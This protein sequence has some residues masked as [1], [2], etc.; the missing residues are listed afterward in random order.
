MA[1]GSLLTEQDKKEFRDRYG[2]LIRQQC[3]SLMGDAQA[4]RELEERVIRSIE[5]KY[6]YQP[7]PE[8]C[9]MMLIARCCI[10]SSR[11]VTPDAEGEAKAGVLLEAERAEPPK[12]EVHPEPGVARAPDDMADRIPEEIRNIRVT[13][14]YDPEKTALWL[15]DGM[16]ADLVREQA[17][18]E[19]PEEDSEERSVPHSILNTFLVITFLGSVVF[20]L[21]KTGV[22]R[23]VN[24][25]LEGMLM[26]G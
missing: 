8:H 11:M 4:A 25:F 23:W 7:L 2:E 10:L 1:S 6:E 12:P 26:Y 3:V 18:P 9:E 17:D 20:F 19:D 14:V 5:D 13:A 24:R 15:P 22:L 21:W 16:Q